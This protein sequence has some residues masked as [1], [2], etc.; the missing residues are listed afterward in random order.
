MTYERT[1][2]QWPDQVDRM[3]SLFPE[4]RRSMLAEIHGDTEALA[5]Y[6]ARCHDLTRREAR[7]TIDGRL[8][9]PH[10]VPMTSDHI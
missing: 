3:K 1:A 10:E 4:T 6:L 8:G 2:K 5:A 9:L 7:D